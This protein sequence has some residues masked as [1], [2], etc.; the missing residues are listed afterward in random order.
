MHPTIRL[1]VV[2]VAA[3]SFS[4]LLPPAT[5]GELATLAKG[6]KAKFPVVRPSVLKKIGSATRRVLNANQLL[7]QMTFTLFQMAPVIEN[8]PVNRMP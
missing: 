2:A 1:L 6:G 8:H 3:T 4:A 5:G 7:T